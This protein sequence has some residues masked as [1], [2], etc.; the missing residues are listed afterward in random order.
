MADVPLHQHWNDIYVKRW[1]VVLTAASAA[2]AAYI[3]SSL[4]TPMF[5]AKTTFYLAA[6][7]TPAS[8]VGPSPDA[9][10]V[11][12]L[13]LPEEK[14]AALDVGILRG[15]EIRARLADEFGL[16][17]A[18][19]ARRVDVT[20]SGEFMIDVF[21]RNPDPDLAAR[22]ANEVPAVYS[23]FHESSMRA[24]ATDLAT[25]LGKRLEA[26]KAQQADLLARQRD[27]RSASL[28]TADDAALN[29]LQTDIETAKVDRNTLAGQIDAATA[30][31]EALQAAL[32][33]EA[34]YYETAKAVDTTPTLD[35]L[36]ES[37]LS[38]Q[39]DLAAL[40][41][42]KTNPRRTAVEEQIGRLEDAV[43]A[44]RRR[45]A[46]AS[47]KVPGSL[48]EE[49]RRELAL[50]RATI[51]ELESSLTAADAR[52]AQA[53]DRFDAVLSAMEGAQ[54]AASELSRVEAQ[55]TT[56]E[57]NLAAARLQAENAKPPLV[58]VETA[59]P[60]TRPAFP[61]PLVNAVAAALCGAIL[62][63][64]YALFVAHGERAAQTRKSRG[65][66]IPLFSNDELDELMATVA[67]LRQTN[68]GREKNAPAASS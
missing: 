35:R 18:E 60:P 33:Q 30:R 62:G 36:L 65:A 14:A 28:T 38:L 61:L 52:I 32:K 31:K 7:A 3:F 50:N 24:R 46:E 47:I 53:T 37:I 68:G 54:D 29:Q 44:E 57:A 5:E 21:V 9:P 13:P 1:L 6:N 56:T 16:S 10:P 58:I 59:V 34:D 41:D 23:E 42:G 4:V 25:A 11:P 66:A 45:L 12:L 19:I 17:V 39:V 26:L 64:Y 2:A 15:R 49:L 48:Y 51:A 8:Y 40:N 20:V 63:T 55:I 27:S 43:A 22:I 67:S